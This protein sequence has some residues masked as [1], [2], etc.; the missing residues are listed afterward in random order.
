MIK[1]FVESDEEPSHMSA[2]YLAAPDQEN[3]NQKLSFPFLKELML[4][5]V[6]TFFQAT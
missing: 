6:G 1:L 4:L 2:T 3:P 5:H